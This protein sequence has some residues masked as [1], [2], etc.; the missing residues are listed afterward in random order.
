MPLHYAPSCVIVAITCRIFAKLLAAAGRAKVDRNV[1][2]EQKAP[3]CRLGV[4][5]HA[6]NRV[7]HRA[8]YRVRG[9]GWRARA[10]GARVGAITFLTV[11]MHA[12]LPFNLTLRTN[13]TARHY[14]QNLR[15]AGPGDDLRSL[16]APRAKGAC[17]VLS[18]RPVVGRSTPRTAVEWQSSGSPG[19]G[20]P[21]RRYARLDSDRQ[22]L[23][24]LAY[25]GA[26]AISATRPSA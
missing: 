12:S 11:G 2:V 10:A 19:P 21:P 7:S 20:H 8:S 15:G 14:S 16:P 3:F 6:A 4:Y 1:I 26:R 9:V 5:I 22:P 24:D 25:R 23:D 13:V 17:R 18:R